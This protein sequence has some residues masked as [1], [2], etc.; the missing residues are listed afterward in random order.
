MIEK[1]FALTAMAVLFAAIL[2]I[3]DRSAPTCVVSGFASIEMT[4]LTNMLLRENNLMK[5]HK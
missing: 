1:I 5:E 3:N 2:L 4:A